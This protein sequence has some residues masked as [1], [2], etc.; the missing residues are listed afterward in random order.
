MAQTYLNPGDHAL[1]FAPTFGEY[2]AACRIAK[3]DIALVQPSKNTDFMW[4][5][6][7]AIDKIRS[8]A[9][10]LVYLC[11][12]NNPTGVYLGRPDIERIADAV[13]TDGLLMLDEA[14]IP[15]VRDP[16]DSR[17]L[18]EREGVV[19]LHSMTKDYALT[20]LRLGYMVAPKGIVSRVAERQ[21]SWSVESLSPPGGANVMLSSNK[22]SH[23]SGDSDLIPA[24]PVKGEGPLSPLPRRERIKVRVKRSY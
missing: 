4:N 5:L 23:K 8:F 24:S 18:L 16:W 15:F 14:Y 10:K 2:E 19:V 22:C 7:S 1:V 21:I 11:N 17:V 6:P 13:G 12:P 3:A 20:A 9:P